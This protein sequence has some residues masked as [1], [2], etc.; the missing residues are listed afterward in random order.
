MLASFMRLNSLVS[1]QLLV[2][3]VFLVQKCCTLRFI[4]KDARWECTLRMITM[5]GRICFLLSYVQSLHGWCVNEW[6]QAFSSH[7]PPR[8]N[9]LVHGLLLG[10]SMVPTFG[11]FPTDH[12]NWE[13][14]SHPTF[15][16]MFKC[17]LI[18]FD[19]VVHAIYGIW[20][21]KIT[22]WSNGSHPTTP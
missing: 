3:L 14:P 7:N 21:H 18:E 6:A 22:N 2:W 15:L 20:V 12:W 17:Q 10:Q 4:S 19:E 9:S 1:H 11:Y 5:L 16:H 8:S 13:V